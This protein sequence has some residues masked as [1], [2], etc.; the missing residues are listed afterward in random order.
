MD[1]CQDN[2]YKCRKTGAKENPTTRSEK[3]IH[4][5]LLPTPRLAPTAYAQFP[6][7]EAT[8]T[9]LR[10]DKGSLSWGSKYCTCK[11]RIT[12]IYNASNNKL[13]YT[14]TASC[15]FTA[16]CANSGASPSGVALTL[17]CKTKAKL[18]LE[19]EQ[20]LNK[21]QSKKIQKQYDEKECQNQ[22]SSRGAVPAGQL[23][24]C[25]APRP[26]QRGHADDHVLEGKE[27]RF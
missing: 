22:P 3:R 4:D 26:G 7:C 12:D 8:R 24:T 21:K 23:L 6:C 19:E 25:M 17:E 10:L 11:T 9:I 27:L 16:H 1:I 18:T 20:I 5:A 14:K 15:S 2:W 13:V